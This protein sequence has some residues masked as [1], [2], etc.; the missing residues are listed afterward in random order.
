MSQQENR[1]DDMRKT[2]EKYQVLIG[3]LKA[4]GRL[5]V[6][7]SGGVDSTF[8]LWAGAEALGPGN[9]LACIAVSPS[10][11][12]R[13]LCQARDLAASFGVR[14]IEL[15]M[16]E[17]ADPA[18]RANKADR[19][20]HCK[21][22]HFGR[23][24]EVARENGI[25]HVACGTNL[26]DKDDYRPGSR[27]VSALGVLT[28]LMD[29]GLTKE[30]I[31]VLSRRAG[32]P[33][34]DQ[35]AT[36]CLASRVAYGAEITAEK[37]RQ[38][39]TAEELLRGLGFPLFR[40]RHHGAIARIEV[41]SRDFARLMAEPLRTRVTADLKALGFTYVALD[42]DGFRSGSLNETLSETEKAPSADLPDNPAPT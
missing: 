21:R 6:G 20:F 36:P 24:L 5:A 19:C 30:D 25:A 18:Y 16:D 33:T 15:E 27:A 9:V 35:P 8:L 34:A 17:L 38:V 3:R 10:L 4:L 11:P 41:P 37:L 28:P 32:L 31:R 2:D 26:D 13:Q 39:E 12:D 1:K 29:A 7:F 23:I 14:L 42:L 40:V 22:S